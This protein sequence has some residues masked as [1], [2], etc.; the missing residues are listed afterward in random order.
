MKIVGLNSSW[1]M[2]TLLRPTFLKG[3]AH[4][5]Q[6]LHSVHLVSTEEMD[7]EKGTETQTHRQSHRQ[8][9]RKKSDA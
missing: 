2:L 9:E 4:E 1:V 8:A 6:S 7:S 3:R 5:I